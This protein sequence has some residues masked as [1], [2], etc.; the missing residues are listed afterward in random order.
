MPALKAPTP[1]SRSITTHLL[2]AKNCIASLGHLLLGQSKVSPG[3]LDNLV[4]APDVLKGG[5]LGVQEVSLDATE[6]LSLKGGV[7]EVLVEGTEN[8][9]AEVDGE[10]GRA[11]GDLGGE[12]GLQKLGGWWDN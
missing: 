10:A 12:V 5:P 8:T 3:H 9:L 11:N 2:Q 4:L 1:S 6:D 7:D